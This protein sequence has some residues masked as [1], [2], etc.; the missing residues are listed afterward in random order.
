MEFEPLLQMVEISK[1]GK[2]IDFLNISNRFNYNFQSGIRKPLF[3][4]SEKEV[5]QTVILKREQMAQD[6]AETQ[7]AMNGSNGH[8]NTG[9]LLL[10]F[11]LFPE[12]KSNKKTT[13]FS[14]HSS[15]AHFV[16]LFHTNQFT[17]FSLHI[18]LNS[19]YIFGVD[20]VFNF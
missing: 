5:L 15:H 10:F 7:L 20:F 13:K 17:C 9:M 18:L 1:V 16:R 19:Q 6:A 4:T 11:L 8:L 12:N 3:T 2:K 14:L